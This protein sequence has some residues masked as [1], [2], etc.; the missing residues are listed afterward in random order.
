MTDRRLEAQ[1][2]YLEQLARA[3]KRDDLAE[4]VRLVRTYLGRERFTVAVVGEFS[5][6]KSSLINALVGRDA[7]PTGATPTTKVPIRVQGGRQACIVAPTPSGRRVY[8]LDD[9]GWSELEREEAPQELAVR[10]PC[11]LLAEGDLELVDTPGVNSQIVNDF[12]FADRALVS[13][14]CAILAVSAVAP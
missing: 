4:Q 5:R 13:C 6:G 11:A 2:D 1:L 7:I 8:P 10:V 3:S 14:D 12:T 9:D